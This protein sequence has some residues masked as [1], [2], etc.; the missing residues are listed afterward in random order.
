MSKQSDWHWSAKYRE[1]TTLTNKDKGELGEIRVRKNL[2]ILKDELDLLATYPIPLAHLKADND[3]PDLYVES[4]SHGFLIEVKNWWSP[5]R[6]D[7][8]TIERNIL[9]K[10][11]NRTAY[12]MRMHS[13]MNQAEQAERPVIPMKNN[14]PAI[15]VL[16]C[17]QIDTWT[18]TAQNA[19][20]EKFGPD[21]VLTEHPIIPEITL[22]DAECSGDLSALLL[23]RLQKVIM[24]NR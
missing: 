1:S 11:W 18:K 7:V 19:V 6:Y 4:Y 22:L 2:Q 12:P 3:I 21:L 14:T 15:P 23:A 24:R 17:T 20:K 10:E 9:A 8:D 13:G 5:R 16:V